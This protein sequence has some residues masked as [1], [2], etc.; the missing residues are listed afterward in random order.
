MKPF[1]LQSIK[2]FHSPSETRFTQRC[3][4]NFVRNFL[5]VGAMAMQ[6]SIVF[7][8]APLEVVRNV[9]LVRIHTIRVVYLVNIHVDLNIERN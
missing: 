9:S 3:F 6:K 5:L 2:H 1:G 8:D 7:K 4:H